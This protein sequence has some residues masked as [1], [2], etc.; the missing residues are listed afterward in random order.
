MF[1]DHHSERLD[2]QRRYEALFLAGAA[3]VIGLVTAIA[4]VGNSA[5]AG[6][7][8]SALMLSGAALM[9]KADRARVDAIDPAQRPAHLRELG[10]MLAGAASF[11]AGLV[12]FV[13]LVGLTS[14]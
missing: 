2:R 9:L 3:G 6:L 1:T 5:P 14:G 12:L 10:L 8:G 13:V 11:V 7:V 4:A